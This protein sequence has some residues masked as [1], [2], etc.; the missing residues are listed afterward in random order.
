MKEKL[1]VKTD[2]SQVLL[3]LA[4]AMLLLYPA[5]A[6]TVE[7]VTS[8]RVVDSRGRDVGPVLGFTTFQAQSVVKIGLAYVPVMVERDA[9]RFGVGLFYSSTNCTG[10]PFLATSSLPGAPFG[11]SIA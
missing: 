3:T 11:Q 5:F 6:Q 2:R 10:A 7:P 1:M 8:L 9:I 4:L